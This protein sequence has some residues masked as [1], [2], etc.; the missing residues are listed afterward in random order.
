LVKNAC[1]GSVLSLVGI[2]EVTEGHR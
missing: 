2:G 1:V